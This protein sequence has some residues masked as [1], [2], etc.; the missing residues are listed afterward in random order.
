MVCGPVR[1]LVDGDLFLSA[2]SVF[3]SFFH[4]KSCLKLRFMWEKAMFLDRPGEEGPEG[5]QGGKNE[6][7]E[8]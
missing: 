6:K 1:A 2:R 3:L 4:P 8:N 7:M 5:R